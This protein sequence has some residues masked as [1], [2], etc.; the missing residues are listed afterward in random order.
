MKL[1]DWIPLY[2]VRFCY[3]CPHPAAWFEAR[4]DRAACYCHKGRLAADEAVPD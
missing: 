1:L 4:T 3:L 2:V